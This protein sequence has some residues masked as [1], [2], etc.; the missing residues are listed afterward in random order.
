MLTA[1]GQ[2]QIENKILDDKLFEKMED[3]ASDPVYDELIR[4]YAPWSRFNKENKDPILNPPKE[5]EW[6]P[7][8]FEEIKE[9][10]KL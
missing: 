3:E 9:G 6:M 7:P 8:D 2:E 4:K 10:V 5:W 1:D